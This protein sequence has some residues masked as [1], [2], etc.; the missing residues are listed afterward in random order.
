MHGGWRMAN[1]ETKWNEHYHIYGMEIMCERKLHFIFDPS[2]FDGCIFFLS[3]FFYSTLN[4]WTMKLKTIQKFRFWNHF[5]WSID[6]C[7]YGICIKFVSISEL[8][9]FGVQCVN[10][11]TQFSC[12]PTAYSKYY[13]Y[14]ISYSV[15]QCANVADF[16]LEGLLLYV[17][18]RQTIILNGYRERIPKF[19][20][21]NE[22]DVSQIVKMSNV[23]WWKVTEFHLYFSQFVFFLLHFEL[24][25]VIWWCWRHSNERRTK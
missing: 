21:K 15:L 2:S 3:F 17:V 22:N 5:K 24:C 19:H 16:G 1:G 25:L 8:R 23:I 12:L 13:Y 10:V 6:T 4:H 9:I 18:R 7:M 11:W 20:R 14:S